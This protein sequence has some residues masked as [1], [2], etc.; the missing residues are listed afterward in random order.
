MTDDTRPDCS[1]VSYMTTAHI[2]QE[3]ILLSVIADI[4]QK[5]GVGDKPM[6]SELADAVRAELAAAREKIEGLEADVA[7]RDRRIAA[8]PNG[9]KS[10]E[11]PGTGENIPERDDAFPLSGQESAAGVETDG[12]EGLLTVIS[13]LA[14][15]L[16]LH[17]T[18]Y[19]TESDDDLL[20][21]HKEVIDRAWAQ[22]CGRM[23]MGRMGEDNG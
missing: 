7:I 10:P 21:R 20:K 11:N 17:G 19:I 14:Q 15:Q 16:V 23:A 9:N 22:E 2:T 13:D 1:D 3:S 5:T 12:V 18:A 6:L 4:R 8:F